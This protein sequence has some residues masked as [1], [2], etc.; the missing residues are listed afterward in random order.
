MCG[1]PIK[2]QISSA[3]DSAGKLELGLKAVQR[4]AL[5]IRSFAPF[6]P[7]FPEVS[8]FLFSISF[9]ETPEC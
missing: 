8:C 6:M 1:Q 5:G 7:V 2:G 9:T 4:L 3:A